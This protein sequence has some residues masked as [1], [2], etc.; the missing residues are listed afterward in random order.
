MDV[1]QAAFALNNDV[2]FSDLCM[3]DAVLMM[4]S[5]PDHVNQAFADVLALLSVR[6]KKCFFT[7][8]E[9]VSDLVEMI[10]MC[11]LGAQCT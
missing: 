10:W 4:N 3:S 11:L 5:S 6:L 8:C 1:L 9:N 2:E 7:F